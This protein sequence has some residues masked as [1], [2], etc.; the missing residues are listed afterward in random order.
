MNKSVLKLNFT[1]YKKKSYQNRSINKKVFFELTAPLST[2]ENNN[3]LK[4]CTV[5]CTLTKV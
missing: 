4:Y 2:Q 3:L 5:I 1:S